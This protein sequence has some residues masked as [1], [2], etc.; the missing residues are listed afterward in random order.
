M[1]YH[2]MPSLL[3]EDRLRQMASL[4]LTKLA[5]P[6]SE[7][8]MHARFHPDRLRVAMLGGRPVYR[9]ARGGAWST[10]F[11]DSGEPLEG[12]ERAAAESIARRFVATPEGRIA[13][14]SVLVEPDQ[15]TLQLRSLMPA[16]RIEF[17]D[18]RETHL[19][20]SIR[21]GDPIM[22]TTRSGRR[23][24]YAG[25]VTHWLYFTP[26]RLRTRLWINTVIWLSIIGCVLALSGIVWGIWRFSLAA[27]YRSRDAC[28]RSPYAGLMRWHH[29]AGLIFGLA[30]FTWVLSGCL[31]L[32]PWNWHPS[33]RPTRAQQVAMAGGHLR[34]DMIT[35]ENLRAGAAAVRKSFA[36]KELEILQFDGEPYLFAHRAPAD[37]SSKVRAGPATFLAPTQPMERATVL[38]SRTEQRRSDGFDERRLLS[39]AGR[40]MPGVTASDVSW[41]ADYDNYYYSRDRSL[42]L[43]VLRLRYLDPQST[44]LYIDPRLGLILHREDRL[45]RLNRW[46][47]H[48]LHSLDFRF[49]YN[50]RPLW[51][52][53][54]IVLC[55][56]GLV[57]CLS[58]IRQGWQRIRRHVRRISS[59]PFDCKFAPS[60]MSR[61]RRRRR[62][63][64][65]P[66]GRDPLR[67]ST[68]PHLGRSL[69]S[70]PVKRSGAR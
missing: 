15:W 68:G 70:S 49:L 4:D 40:A 8:A 10:V 27:R 59:S 26:F 16:H 7:A 17:D 14:S 57:L 37:G 12:I 66:G 42:D 25:A 20:V 35:L 21:T 1:M 64:L 53:T 29:Y 43:P 62:P 11:A 24:G 41:L 69:V 6:P 47:Y 36:P 46:L 13:M 33:S 18:A 52:I 44:W 65:L 3:P 5:V 56:G 67:R 51:D 2:R 32:D 61:I 28:Y 9:F 50:R 58:P 38:L 19:Y 34:L 55:L 63:C 39:A 22:R 54:V 30:T 31:S 45:T 23:W 48:G 60:G